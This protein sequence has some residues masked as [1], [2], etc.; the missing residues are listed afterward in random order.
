MNAILLR[1]L[2]ITVTYQGSPVGASPKKR[3][4]RFDRLIVPDE[5]LVMIWCDGHVLCRRENTITFSPEEFVREITLHPAFVQKLRN[6]QK[7]QDTLFEGAE[8][9]VVEVA[10]MPLS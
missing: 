6:Y 3:E 8:N 4:K 10:L 9:L 5:Q 1:P 7:A 2:E